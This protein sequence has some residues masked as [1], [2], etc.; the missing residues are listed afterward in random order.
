MQQGMSESDLAQ[1]VDTQ[2]LQNVLNDFD[3]Q[4]FDEQ[5]MIEWANDHETRS[6]TGKLD[7]YNTLMEGH[8]IPLT[9]SPEP[10]KD[11]D[12]LSSLLG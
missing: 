10:L 2:G 3:V 12:A 7:V 9:F 4:D 11:E 6:R 1:F 8:Q 5:K